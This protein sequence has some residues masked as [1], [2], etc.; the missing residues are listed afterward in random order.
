[1]TASATTHSL[2]R[3]AYD[4]HVHAAPDVIPRAQ[5][6]LEL[7]AAAQEAGMAGMV[8]KDHTTSTAGRV[9]ALNKLYAGGPRFFSALALNPPVG[10]LNPYAVEAA[11]RSGADIIYFPTYGAQHQIRVKGSHGFPPAYPLPGD[12]FPGITILDPDGALKPEVEAILD[13]IAEHD[14]VLATGHLSAQECLT[15]LQAAGEH[16][17]RR[18]MVTHPSEPVPGMSIAEQSQAVGLGAF[19]EHCYLPVLDGSLS[20]AEIANQIRQVGVRHAIFSSDLG[21]AA[22]GPVVPG[23]ARGLETLREAGFTEAEIRTMTSDNPR[24]LLEGRKLN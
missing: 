12:D 20:M 21:Q 19:M 9:Y 3:G 15:L 2:L 10:S 24:Q 5:D 6:L 11:L 8:I 1:M 7:A 16:G 18:M 23:F 22:N 14:A 17:V 4:I 13:R